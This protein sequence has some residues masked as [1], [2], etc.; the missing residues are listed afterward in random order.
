MPVTLKKEPVV[1]QAQDLYTAEHLFRMQCQERWEAQLVIFST[2]NE[3]GRFCVEIASTAGD[4]ADLYGSIEEA[5]D[6]F[7]LVWCE[8]GI[9]RLWQ[10][11][12]EKTFG[13]T[14]TSIGK[15]FLIEQKGFFPDYDE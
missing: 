13:G 14:V 8:D 3:R 11:N 7:R 10:G 6:A 15:K 5:K 1:M 2:V 4:A 12:F 9:A